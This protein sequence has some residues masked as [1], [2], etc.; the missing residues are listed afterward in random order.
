MNCNVWHK[1][2]WRRSAA[3]PNLIAVSTLSAVL[4]DIDGTLV[5]SNYVHVSGLEQGAGGAGRARGF[6]A[7]PSG[8][9][10]GRDLSSSMLC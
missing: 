8:H 5:D 9:W 7:D 4:F 2:A 1:A 6:L 3:A 10:N